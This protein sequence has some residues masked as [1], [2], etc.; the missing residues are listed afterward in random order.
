MMWKLVAGIIAVPVA[1]GAAVY[2]VGALLPRDHVARVEAVLDA[3]RTEVA[4]IVREVEGQPRWRSGVER[5]ELLERSGGRLRYVEHSGDGAIAF[6][7]IE[8]RP[9]ALFRSTIADPALPFA[10]SW[11]IALAHEGAVTRVKIE[12]RG[13]VKDP[14]YRF[15]SAL[16][17]GHERTLKAYA[18]DLEEETRRKSLIRQRRTPTEAGTTGS[19]GPRQGNAGEIS[20]RSRSRPDRFVRRL[21]CHPRGSA[22]VRAQI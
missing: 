16:V 2:G 14:L 21:S 13:S 17:F 1:L 6:E 22:G 18:A 11:T 7:F 15:F 20:R 12:E 19:P 8:E 9:D 3:P 10:G 4:K 5:I